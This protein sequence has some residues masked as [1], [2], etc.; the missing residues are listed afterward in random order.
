[1]QRLEIRMAAVLLI[2][3]VGATVL[4]LGSRS[5]AASSGPDGC[6]VAFRDSNGILADATTLC[7]VASGHICT[8][9]LALCVNEPQQGCTASSFQK[10]KFTAMGHCGPVRQVS[11]SPSGTSSVCGAFT[12]VKVRTRSSGKKE[13][14]CRIMAAVRTGKT[15]ARTDVDHLLLKCE[16][17]TGSCPASP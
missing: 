14:R 13:G 3:A 6:L 10:K 9:N 5:F 2:V 11:V 7:Q 15:N 1:M 8:F 17:P 12:G 4:A 16:P